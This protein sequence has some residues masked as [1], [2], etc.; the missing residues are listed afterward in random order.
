MSC[1]DCIS[2][3]E[4][5][6]LGAIHTR[7]TGT[8]DKGF[9]VDGDTTTYANVRAKHMNPL[10][11]DTSEVYEFNQEVALQKNSWLIRNISTQTITAKKM[12]YV[13]GGN[14]HEIRGVRRYKGGRKYL[15]L[16]TILRDNQTL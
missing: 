4:F 10:R 13:E 6:V 12:S 9:P 7:D 14:Y 1:K 16:D 8:Y 11:T 5:D 15:V 2:A 3:S